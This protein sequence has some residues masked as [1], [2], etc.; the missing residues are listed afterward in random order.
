MRF[1]QEFGA[2]D[3]HSH[4]YGPFAEYPLSPKRTFDPPERSIEQL[5]DIWE[6]LGI[7]RSVLVQGSSYGYDHKALLAGLARSPET[8]RGVALLPFDVPDK[9]LKELHLAGIR[10][11]RFNWIHHLLGSDTRSEQ[12]RLAEASVLLERVSALGWHAEIHIDIEDLN[13][14][15]RLRAPDQ[16]PLVI[17]HMARI[18]VAAPDGSAQLG[19]LLTVLEDERFWVKVSGADRLAAKCD[20][21]GSALKPMRSILEY[22]PDR[23]VWG[24]DWPHVNLSRKRTDLELGD[25][26]VEAAGGEKTLE[27]VLIQNPAKLYGFSLKAA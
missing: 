1:L 3:C 12:Q 24:L 27:R 11:T 6:S 25:I 21:L 5:E 23:C 22:A 14:L 17:D 16:M 18:D 19:R 7:E 26:L 2:C 10:A 4:V 13:L 8:R 15:T 9:E 20:D